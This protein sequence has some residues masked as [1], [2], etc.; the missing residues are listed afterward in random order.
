MRQVFSCVV[1]DNP[2]Y[3]AQSYFWLNCLLEKFPPNNIYVHVAD[4]I[5]DYDYLGWLAS[6]KI[7]I[8]KSQMNPSN[9]YCNKL[10]QL[11]TFTDLQNQYDQLI[12][13]DCDTAY[14]GGR[15]FPVAQSVLAKIS[16]FGLPE[17][18]TIIVPRLNNLWVKHANEIV[19]SMILDSTRNRIYIEQLALALALSQLVIDVEPLAL[20]WN[21][22]IYSAKWL[23]SID[24]LT[25]FRR[26]QPVNIQMLHYHD[27]LFADS[28]GDEVL[29]RPLSILKHKAIS[30]KEPE[31]L[32]QIM[33]RRSEF[34]LK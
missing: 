3:M 30:W 26:L 18:E 24:M 21:T 7:H 6:Q 15:S 27:Q 23:S 8:I 5:A 9:P 19:T 16:D 22:P 13:M 11:Q 31:W 17:E 34:I 2:K 4:T 33:L 10:V 14:I 12:M 28:T 25:E 1:D 20:C 32:K 29:D